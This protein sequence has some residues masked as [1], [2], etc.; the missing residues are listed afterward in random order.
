MV[1]GYHTKYS[2]MKWAMFFLGEYGAMLNVASMTTTLFLGGWHGP[3]PSPFQPGSI[4]FCVEG[5]FWFCLKIYI[6][7]WVYIWIRGTLPRLRY[8]RLMDFTWKRMLPATLANV[9]LIA[10]ILTA[11]YR[12]P[13]KDVPEVLKTAQNDVGSTV[14]TMRTPSMGGSL[15][16][17]GP[18]VPG[19]GPAPSSQFPTGSVL[20]GTSGMSH[21]LGGGKPAP[22]T[23]PSEHTTAPAGSPAGGAGGK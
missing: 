5:I 4:P 11:F 6:I 3:Y 17:G 1:G 8:D 12:I 18:T 22:S 2:G 7:L 13:L 10:T 21:S 9:L 23:P 14:P 19:G 16:P 20:P 15:R